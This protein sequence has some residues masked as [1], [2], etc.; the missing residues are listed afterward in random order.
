[1]VVMK[2]HENR[3]DTVGDLL[4]VDK[5]E[6]ERI[7]YLY[8]S[9]PQKMIRAILDHYVRHN[10]CASWKQIATALK[11]MGLDNLAHV[12]TVDHVRGMEL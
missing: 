1:M 8:Q 6:R 7:G 4:G 9:D 3:W 11:R 12:V 10:R 5:A 2:G